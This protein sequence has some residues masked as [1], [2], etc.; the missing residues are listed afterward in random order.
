MGR[1][2]GI[3]RQMVKVIRSRIKRK[4]YSQFNRFYRYVTRLQ[5][6]SVTLNHEY[7]PDI[8]LMYSLTS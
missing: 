2:Q 5:H 1:V 3:M 7:A 8:T 6:A 4:R